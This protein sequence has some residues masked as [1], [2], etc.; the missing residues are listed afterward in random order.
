MAK[1][2]T[3][4]GDKMVTATQEERTVKG[5]RLDLS[6]EDHKRLE[7]TAKQLGL[8]MASYA[9]M[10]LFERLKADESRGK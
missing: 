2:A 1:K 9:R 10:A 4:K 8:T 6:P 3:T 7:R 5:V